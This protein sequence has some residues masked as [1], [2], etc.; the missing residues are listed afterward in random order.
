MIGQSKC[1]NDSLSLEVSAVVNTVSEF[2]VATMPL[3]ATYRLHVDPKQR[4][5]VINILCLGYLVCIAGCLRTYYIWKAV[6]SYDYTW[7]SGPQW[8]A[9]ELEIDTALVSFQSLGAN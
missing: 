4:W 5:S 1:F 6:S 7:W 3:L 9:S 8:I 2:W